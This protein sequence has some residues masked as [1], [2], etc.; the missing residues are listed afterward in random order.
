L[1]NTVERIAPLSRGVLPHQPTANQAAINAINA[2]VGLMLYN[3]HSN[4]WNYA[5]LEDRSGTAVAPLM[6]ISDAPS[7][8]NGEKLFVGLSMTC[9]TSQFAMPAVTGTLDELF[10][11][12]ATGG[13]VATW[14]PSGQ[15]VAHGHELLAKGLCE[16]VAQFSAQ[17]PAH[18]RAG[19]RPATTIC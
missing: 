19:R 14:G 3:G 5:K 10:V 2:G 13:A 7:L 9:L 12:S 4:H 18:G 16:Q 8:A 15:S 6:S 17:Q 1:F 11:R